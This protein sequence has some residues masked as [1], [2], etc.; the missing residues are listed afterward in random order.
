LLLLPSPTAP[1]TET[2]ASGTPLQPPWR[3]NLQPARLWRGKVQ[4]MRRLTVVHRLL[5]STI[6]RAQD[7]GIDSGRR[8]EE[9]KGHTVGDHNFTPRPPLAHSALNCSRWRWCF[10][11]PFFLLRRTIQ[12]KRMPR[13]SV[14]ALYGARELRAWWSLLSRRRGLHS[15]WFRS[16]W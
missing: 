15:E 14:P 3:R 6:Q 16:A 12:G 8:I 5:G 4:R 11:S 2:R 13:L 1:G 9:G 10:L 7:P